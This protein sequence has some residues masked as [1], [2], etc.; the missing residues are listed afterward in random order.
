MLFVS[1]VAALPALI[2]LWYSERFVDYCGHSNILMAAFSVYILRYTGLALIDNPWWT[3]FM[4]AMEPITLGITWVTLILYMRHLMSRR[5][6]ATGQA[7]P[8]IAFFCIGK[9]IGAM[10]GLIE[11]DSSLLSIQCLYVGMAIAACIV[12][13]VYFFLYHFLL[14]P[15]CAASTQPLPSPS[16]LQS[17]AN[18]GSNGNTGSNGNYTPLR[19]YHNARGQKGEFRY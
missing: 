18:G 13:V 11:P 16:E 15:K 9:S 5:L 12:A 14:A 3:L 1:T 8:V 7:L 6:T 19:V 2:P 10:L 17:H 4:A